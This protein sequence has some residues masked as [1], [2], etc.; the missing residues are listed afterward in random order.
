MPQIGAEELL[1]VNLTTSCPPPCSGEGGNQ[2]QEGTRDL[3]K[4]PWEQE[5]TRAGS[6]LQAELWLHHPASC[7]FQY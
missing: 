1:W 7:G 2:G 5:N 3:P 4:V 6:E